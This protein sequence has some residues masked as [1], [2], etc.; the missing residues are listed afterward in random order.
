MYVRKKDL[1]KGLGPVSVTTGPD[2][3]LN[4]WQ[5]HILISL[6]F[7]AKFQMLVELPKE[8]SVL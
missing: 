2:Q 6:D 3:P 8:K 5:S 4:R 7:T 1:N